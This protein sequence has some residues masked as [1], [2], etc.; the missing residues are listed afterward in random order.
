MVAGG[1]VAYHRRQRLRTP[2]S[3]GLEGPSSEVGVTEG[4]S[5]VMAP[6]CRRP[7]S[8]S[9]GRGLAPSCPSTSWVSWL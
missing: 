1:S 9:L 3:Q 4:L 7:S 8:S 6:P 5:A 2:V